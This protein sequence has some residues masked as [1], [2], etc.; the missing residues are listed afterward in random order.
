MKSYKVNV[1]SMSSQQTFS[2]FRRNKIREDL[3]SINRDLSLERLEELADQFVNNF[4]EKKW[5][6]SAYGVSKV[7]V[8]GLTR[9]KVLIYV[10]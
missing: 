10:T 2:A 7:F 3:Y 8:N 4:D 1:S 9:E 5:P 6:H